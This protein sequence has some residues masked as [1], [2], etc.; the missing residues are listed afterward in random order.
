[1]NQE[2]EDLMLEYLLRKKLKKE[3]APQISKPKLQ[4]KMRKTRRHPIHKWSEQDFA[5]VS[6]MYK[7]GYEPSRIAKEMGLRTQQIKSAV[8]AMQ[9]KNPDWNA[10]KLLV[11]S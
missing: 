11:N 1:M 9:G 8:M 4:S 3:T 6:F 2:L 7:Q 10:P 5:K